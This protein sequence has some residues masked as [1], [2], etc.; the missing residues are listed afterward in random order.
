MPDPLADGTPLEYDSVGSL[1]PLFPTLVGLP[2]V[3]VRESKELGLLVASR[4]IASLISFPA[5]HT[6]LTAGGF[7]PGGTIRM[8]TTVYLPDHFSAGMFNTVGLIA[9]R[10]SL[11]GDIEGLFAK[12]SHIQL[13]MAE[14]GG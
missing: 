7:P 12:S 10:V 8:R 14:V 2:L 3:S 9:I 4:L 11:T 5:N 6:T 13:R 1:S